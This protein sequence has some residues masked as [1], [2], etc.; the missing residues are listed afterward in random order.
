M[1]SLHDAGAGTPQIVDLVSEISK[2]TTTSLLHILINLK[3]NLAKI[4]CDWT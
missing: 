3:K 4:V 2:F 1:Q